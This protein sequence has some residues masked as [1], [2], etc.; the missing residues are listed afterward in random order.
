MKPKM[1]A[2]STTF[3]CITFATY[4]ACAQQ[5]LSQIKDPAARAAA[6]TIMEKL[7]DVQEYSCV[8]DSVFLRTTGE[9]GNV[10]QIEE[11][12]RC[13]WYFRRPNLGMRRCEDLKKDTNPLS[14][15]TVME[16]YYDGT[17]WWEYQQRPVGFGEKAA[18]AAGITDIERRQEYIDFMERPWVI[19]YALQPFIDAG[20][21]GYRGDQADILLRPFKYCNLKTLSLESETEDVW[22]FTAEPARGDWL[23]RSY[24]SERIVVGKADGVRRESNYDHG[25][26]RGHGSIT[27]S[28]VRLNPELDDSTFHFTPPQGVRVVDD[29]DKRIEFLLKVR[30]DLER[31]TRAPAEQ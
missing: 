10:R 1:L 17:Y 3:L 12:S 9:Q 8:V 13:E 19:K 25:D 15:G 7:A 6:E 14:E 21:D 30:E 23:P 29:T 31:S 5:D 18:D 20:L 11:V 4:S 28:N 24:V 16:T 27:I 22:I 2:L 26:L